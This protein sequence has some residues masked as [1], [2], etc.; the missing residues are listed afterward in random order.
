MEKARKRSRLGSSED[1]SFDKGQE[2]VEDD[3]LGKNGEAAA[4]GR[5]QR[6]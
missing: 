5:E 3:G 6:S 4:V 2:K 1:W